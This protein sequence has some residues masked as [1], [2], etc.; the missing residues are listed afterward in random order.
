[1]ALIEKP[2]DT[3]CDDQKAAAEPDRTPPFDQGDGQRAGRIAADTSAVYGEG[4][5]RHPPSRSKL[6]QTANRQPASTAPLPSR[7]IHFSVRF[8]PISR[9]VPFPRP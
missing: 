7:G 8:R 9:A 6:S 5:R 4:G 2:E 1:M 3:E